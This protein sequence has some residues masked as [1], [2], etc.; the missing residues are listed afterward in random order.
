MEVEEKVMTHGVYCVSRGIPKSIIEEKVTSKYD[1]LREKGKE[2]VA[3]L[4]ND[5]QYKDLVALS[6]CE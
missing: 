1:I 6:F 3:V 2:K 4:K 5:N